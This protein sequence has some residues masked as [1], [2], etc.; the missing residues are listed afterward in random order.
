M[1]TEEKF[2]FQWYRASFTSEENFIK[3]LNELSKW[4]KHENIKIVNDYVVYY[5]HHTYLIL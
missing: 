4:V 2:E 1:I 5:Y 3:C